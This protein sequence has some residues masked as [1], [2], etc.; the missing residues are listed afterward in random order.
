MDFFNTAC[1]EPS[2]RH[3]LFGICD[4]QDG[5]KAFTDTEDPSEW[6]ATV[7]NDDQKLLVFTAIDKCVIKDN[8]ENDRGRCDAMLTSDNILYLIELKD[9]TS[10]WQKGAVDQL[11]STIEILQENHDISGFKHKKAFACNKR[12]PRFQEIDNELN[13]RFYRKYGFRI[14]IQAEIIIAK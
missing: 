14:D 11:A 6:V 1:Q 12:R 9:A 2:F 4:D 13:L 10:H 5:G 3:T 8:E 7:K